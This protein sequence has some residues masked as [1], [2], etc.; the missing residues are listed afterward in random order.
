ME[1]RFTPADDNNTDKSY[2]GCPKWKVSCVVLS[3]STS[4]PA[5]FV[6]M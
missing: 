5:S 3:T 1:F 2:S 4:H 6:C